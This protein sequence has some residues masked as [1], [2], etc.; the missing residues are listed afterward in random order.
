MP[1]SFKHEQM[2]HEDIIQ[3]SEEMRLHM[4][5]EL[6]LH[7]DASWDDVRDA[8]DEHTRSSSAKVLGLPE[9]AS[10]EQILAAENGEGERVSSALLLGLGRDASYSEIT[11]ER[12][13]RKKELHQKIWKQMREK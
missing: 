6:G 5:Q 3:G 2:P 11:T 7:Q 13:K 10:W 12:L 4:A 8:K 9:D 1:E